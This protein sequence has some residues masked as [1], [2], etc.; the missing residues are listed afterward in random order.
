[1]RRFLVGIVAVVVIAFLGLYA[2]TAA[3]NMSNPVVLARYLTTPTSELGNVFASRELAPSSNSQMIPTTNEQR[4]ETV[5]WKGEQTL[6]DGFLKE[7]KT[8]SFIVMCEGRQTFRWYETNEDPDRTQSSWSVAKSFLSL[9][10]GQLIDE[11]KLSEST[12]LVEVLP[13]YEAGTE[14]DDITVGHLL[15][16]SSGIDLDESYSYFKPFWGV[17]GLQITTDLPGYLKKNQGMRFAPGSEFD[18][19]SV[20]S[21]YLS[22]IVAE[23]ENDTMTNILQERIWE[24]LRMEDFAKWNLDHEGG[25]EKGFAAVNATP[26]DFAKLGLLVAN[27]GKVGDEQVVS[28][29]WIKRISTPAV[30]RDDGWAYSGQWWHPPGSKEHHDMTALGVYGQYVYINPDKDTVIVKLGDYDAERDEKETIEVFREFADR[31]GDKS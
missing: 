1:M 29:A 7:T 12:K 18:Y 6:V 22:M 4:L 5:S 25:I 10:V 15:D 28:E 13:E 14:F 23:I 24:P 19:R 16:M 26:R 2:L 11:G 21:Q 9:I 8:N 27:N 3:L 17:G 30:T 31:C 20:D